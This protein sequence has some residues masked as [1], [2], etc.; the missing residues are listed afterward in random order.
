[1]QMHL[2]QSHIKIIHHNDPQKTKFQTSSFR[3][4]NVH[5][6][7]LFIHFPEFLLIPSRIHDLQHKSA[8]DA[9]YAATVL[10]IV[11]VSGW[12]QKE[13]N[14]PLIAVEHQIIRI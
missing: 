2:F 12:G 4:G 9:Y 10:G 6:M 5:V 8:R 11:S 3:M 13:I 7:F 14:P 1:M